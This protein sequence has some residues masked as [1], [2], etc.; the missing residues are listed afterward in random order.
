MMKYF[1]LSEAGQKSLT[2][3]VVSIA[4]YL[5]AIWVANLIGGLFDWVILLGK[6]VKLVVWLFDV[7]C[8]AGIVVAILKWFK[9]IK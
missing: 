5:I 2:H 4:F 3:L 1:P 9:V 7:Y 8:V 6:L